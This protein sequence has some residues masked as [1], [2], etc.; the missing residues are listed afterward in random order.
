[1]L[2]AIFRRGQFLVAVGL[3]LVPAMVA[4][5]FINM[6]KQMVDSE[7]FSIGMAVATVWTGLVLLSAA[8]M[9]LVVKVLRK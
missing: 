6:G 8:N 4:L 9:V 1:M 7:F 5:L 2:G 3:S